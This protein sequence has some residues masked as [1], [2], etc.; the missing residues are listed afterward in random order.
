[1]FPLFLLYRTPRIRSAKD[2]F[3]GVVNV[4]TNWDIWLLEP[5]YI[6]SST[7]DPPGSDLTVSQLLFALKWKLERLRTTEGLNIK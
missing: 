3:Q 2:C 6:H 5:S 1:M 7:M 4:D